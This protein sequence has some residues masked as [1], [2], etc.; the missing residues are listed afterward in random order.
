M[1]KTQSIMNCLMFSIHLIYKHVFAL[2]IDHCK[3]VETTLSFIFYDL[4][5]TKFHILCIKY[6]QQKNPADLIFLR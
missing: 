1:H 3:V 6:L 2:L 4:I 5:F